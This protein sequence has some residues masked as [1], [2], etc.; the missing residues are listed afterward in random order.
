MVLVYSAKELVGVMVETIA[1]L[2]GSRHDELEVEGI[3]VGVAVVVAIDS[4]EIV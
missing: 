4:V 3:I 2:L 1:V